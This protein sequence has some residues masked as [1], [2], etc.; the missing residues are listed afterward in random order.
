MGKLDTFV[1]EDNILI[2]AGLIA[3]LEELTPVEVVATANDERSAL[4][5]LA[6]HRCDLVLID[7]FLKGG[8]GPGVLTRAR[9]FNKTAEFIVLSNYATPSVRRRCLDLGASKVF[10]K[11]SELDW[12]IAYCRSATIQRRRRLLM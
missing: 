8:S 7:I 3:A 2:R 6:G 9:S 4:K 10:D 1:V 12:L 11:S 5:W